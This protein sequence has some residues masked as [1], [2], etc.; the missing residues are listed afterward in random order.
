VVPVAYDVDGTREACIEGK[1]GRLVS[2]GNRGG[3]RQAVL[4]LAD[5]P[6]ERA[7]LAAAGR[8]LCRVRFAAETMVEHLEKV[9]EQALSVARR[10]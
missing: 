8:E 6:G 2:A 7:R 5:S 1:T 10:P 9:Y 4:E 3:L